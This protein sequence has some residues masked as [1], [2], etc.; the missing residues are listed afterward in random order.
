[1][2][3]REFFFTLIFIIPVFAI[4]AT[5]QFLEKYNNKYCYFSPPSEWTL[6][7]PSSV[8]KH[9]KIAFAGPQDQS[10]TPSVNLVVEKL[11]LG[12]T[13]AK[14]LKAVKS[15]HRSNKNVK[16]R[17]LGPLTCR[18][19]KGQITEIIRKEK[20]ATLRM[21]QFILVEG[22][23]AYLLTSC[24]EESLFQK[25]MPTFLTT[26]RSLTTTPD[27][28]DEIPSPE[29]RESFRKILKNLSLC[30]SATKNL[31]KANWADVQNK[32]LYDYKEMGK[33]WQVLMTQYVHE[34][35]LPSP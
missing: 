14:Y 30:S 5:H 35:Y 21:L 19:G 24:I 26:A 17:D 8:S 3:I 10:F 27:L 15:I 33:H 7:D 29:K 31:Q 11:S 16:W 25:Y 13:L 18:S 28:V 32:I 6:I 12:M 20:A 1:M 4:H 22:N 34:K 23:Y 9:V 2:R